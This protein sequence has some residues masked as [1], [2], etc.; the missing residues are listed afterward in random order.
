MTAKTI[1]PLWTDREA[2]MRNQLK[3]LEKPSDALVS[4]DSFEEYAA[5]NPIFTYLEFYVDPIE[6]VK[7]HRRYK[8][9]EVLWRFDDVDT[10]IDSMA[11]FY[12]GFYGAFQIDENKNTK[13][14]DMVFKEQGRSSPGA[15]QASLGEFATIH[16]A[17]ATAKTLYLDGQ[18]QSFNNFKEQHKYEQTFSSRLRPE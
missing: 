9:N 14:C 13:V 7:D 16:D 10:I 5:H 18:K 1:Q 12:G 8:S 2:V 4:Y 15:Q 11:L 17:I 3:L 6:W